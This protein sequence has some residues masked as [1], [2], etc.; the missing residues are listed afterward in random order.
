[1]I[2]RPASVNV[3]GRIYDLQLP[4]EQRALATAA[5]LAA[6]RPGERVLDV[7]TGTGGLLRELAGRGARPAQAVGLDRSASMLA[8][9]A[10]RL[11]PG[12]S[13]ARGDARHLPFPD[14]SFE[15]VS[16][17]YLLHPLAPN[18]RR[19]VLAEMARVVRPDGGAVT[20]TVE[21]RRAVGRALLTWLPRRAGVRP[22]DPARDLRAAGLRPVRA[23]F[24]SSGWP[25]LCV[26]SLG[27]A[28][29]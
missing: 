2:R 21:S 22:L 9:A 23:R 13:L 1:M 6:V 28:E 27:R 4:L 14:R 8:L 19:Q 12:W 24:V 18:D 20:I 26:L 29:A 5:E 15:V 10:T 17:C 25:S 3:R 16:A 11:P 7:A